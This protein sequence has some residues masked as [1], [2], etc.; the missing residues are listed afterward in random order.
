MTSVKN[1]KR[2]IA[3]V[4]ASRANYA[5][6]KYLIKA[7]HESSNLELQLIVG[8][9][10]LL[11][12]FGRVID[13]IKNDGYTVNWKIHY[14][15]EGESLTTQA[16]STGLGII[17]LSTAFQE[18][19]PD[20]VVTV[21]DRYET[22]STAIAASYLNIPLAHVQGGEVSGNI[23][24]SVRHAITKL[25]HLHFPSTEKSAERI[26]QMGEEPWRV[27]CTGCPAIDILK[28]SDLSLPPRSFF[29]DKGT[30]RI[31]E[32]GSPFILIVQH[33][34]TSSFGEGSK[35]IYETLMAVK[36]IDLAKIVL[37]PNSDAGSDHVAKTIRQ[38]QQKHT[39]LPFSYH[40]NFSP[41][42]YASLLANAACL[43]GNSSS[44]IREGAFLGTPAVIIGDRQSGREHGS[45]VV[46]SGYDRKEIKQKIQDQVQ[47]GKYPTQG[48]FG[49]GDAG[50]AIAEH[51]ENSVLDLNKKNMY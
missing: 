8:A 27:K 13:V 35:Q 38:F 4:V 10:A 16:K 50:R 3:I 28:H 9:S 21:A 45:N 39:D 42:I 31:F 17:E 19:E 1:N 26:I 33:P 15:V 11:Y 48:L 22:M 14:L 49:S 2:K 46:F 41:E 36:D 37:W 43:I 6:I 18:L 24:N 51:L 30:G 32:P 29:E 47:H 20:I 25:A 7:V 5:R 40:I 12:K 34:V 23:D 44:F